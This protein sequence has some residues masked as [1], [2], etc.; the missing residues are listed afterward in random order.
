MQTYNSSGGRERPKRLNNPLNV[1]TGLFVLVLFAA[2]GYL[3]HL[4]LVVTGLETPL[5]GL[6]GWLFSINSVQ[7]W[8]YVTRASG[9]VAYL[10]LWLSTA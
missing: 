2:L 4:L 10:L 5:A 7:L 1:M 6:T 8:W 3:A 9:L